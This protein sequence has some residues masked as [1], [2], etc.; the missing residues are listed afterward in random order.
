MPVRPQP[1]PYCVKGSERLAIVGELG[2]VAVVGYVGEIAGP[3]DT[4]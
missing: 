2:A 1:Y 3:T 4:H